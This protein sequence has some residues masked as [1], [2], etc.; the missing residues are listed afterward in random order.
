MVERALERTLQ[1]ALEREQMTLEALRL[2]QLELEGRERRIEQLNA[3]CQTLATQ[4]GQL[5]NS[6]SWKLTRPYRRIAD[7]LRG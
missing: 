7:R 6:F 1:E 4:L 5:R 3:E 2:K